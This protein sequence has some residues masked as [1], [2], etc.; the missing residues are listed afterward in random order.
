MKRF[1]RLGLAALTLAVANSAH[2]VESRS[3]SENTS[4]L[5]VSGDSLVIRST[6]LIHQT[7]G[8]VIEK[9]DADPNIRK[10]WLIDV[11]GGFSI[12][13]ARLAWRA[14][15]LDV[16]VGGGCYSACA[17]VALA[18]RSLRVSP[19]QGRMTAAIVVHGTFG[20]DG[21]WSSN[22]LHDLARYA[23]RLDP[24]KQADI[25]EA[26]RYPYPVAAGLFIFTDGSVPQAQGKTTLLCSH[27]PRKC[28]D[29]DVTLE[30]L[31]I[32]TTD[33]PV[34]PPPTEDTRQAPSS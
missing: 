11:P 30:Q 7:V 3:T 19:R 14:Q 28:R 22:G 9:L 26:L 16:I 4:A 6:A 13:G 12:P 29:L 18:A 25:E 24:I 31:H 33:E 32:S 21:T 2:S 10:L 34:P 1:I 20:M 23:A 27:F 5:Y 15:E 17:D 8:E